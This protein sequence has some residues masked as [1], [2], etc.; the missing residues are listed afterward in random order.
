MRLT[1]CFIL[2]LSATW[3]SSSAEALTTLQT[4]TS[5]G[6]YRDYRQSA[7]Y[8]VYHTWSMHGFYDSGV[9]TS[10]DFLLN[11]DFAVNQW[12]FFP[13]HAEISAPI[14]R[15]WS[16]ERQSRVRLGRQLFTEGFDLSLLDGVQAPIYWSTTGGVM[17]FA[18]ALKSPDMDQP[19][20]SNAPIVGFAVW[21]RVFDFQIRA[22]YTA[23][24]QDL[25]N[26]YVHA[27][28]VRQWDSWLWSPQIL[29]KEEW[30]ADDL[31][32]NQSSSE[33]SLAL[34]PSLDFRVGYANLQPRPLSP[35]QAS[36][37][38]YRY[39]AISPTELVNGDFTWQV[40]TASKISLGA[41]RAFYNS[42]FQNEVADRQDLGAS[43]EI[44]QG[45][46]LAPSFTH[47]TTYGGQIHDL[48]LRYTIDLSTNS[49]C[50]LEYDFAYVDKVNGIHGW[51][52]HA[53]TSYETRIASR[54][55]AMFSLEAERNH[56][57]E[58]DVRTMAY[59]TNYL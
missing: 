28:L 14:G 15:R 58:F 37:F 44:A 17:P 40:G 41:Q 59:V 19:N 34:S 45:Q 6:F 1:S 38:V 29:L 8:P 27:G 22:G 11:N 55:K 4:S 54:A 56:Y 52:Q 10:F 50:N 12:T 20:E 23:R 32:F 39:F 49:G 46:W 51:V 43:F 3:L 57:F 33:L 31:T 30:H 36:N 53:R 18:G 25:A 24:E 7:H 16:P 5:V 9:E 35:N 21:E 47:M 13:T 48:G 42:G 2:L 26:R